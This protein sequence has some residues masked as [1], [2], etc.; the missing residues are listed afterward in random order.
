[1]KKLKAR[2]V[3]EPT[4]VHKAGHWQDM[5]LNT[6]LWPMFRDLCYTEISVLVTEMDE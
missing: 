6:S 3:P 2:K 5:D 4:Q 1:M